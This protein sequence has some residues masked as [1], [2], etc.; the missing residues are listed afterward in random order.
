MTYLITGGA[1]FIGTNLAIAL[2]NDN[3][4]VIIYDNLSRK[5]TELNIKYLTD[6][7]KNKLTFVEGDIRNKTNLE[8]YMKRVDVVF[9]LAGHVSITGSIINPVEDFEVNAFGSLYLLES[10]RKV[11]NPPLIIYSSTNK[12]Y[13]HLSGIPI[14]ESATRYIFKNNHDKKGVKESNP[15]DFYT[16]YGCSK[17]CG[18]QYFIDYHRI[19]G[20]PTIVFRQ[21]CIYGPHQ[22]G[23]EDQGW[24]AW[25]LIATEL[26]LPLRIYGNGKQVRDILHVNDLINAYRIAV[27]NKNISAGNVYNIGGGSKY[28]ISIWQEFKEIITKLTNKNINPDFLKWRPGDQKI[29]YSDNSKLAKQLGWTP[30]IDPLKGTEDIYTWIKS[31]KTYFKNMFRH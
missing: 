28:T 12:V 6:R 14:T 20:I 27:K 15:L 24:V 29:F 22:F 2:L 19:F 4:E 25:F 30:T 31:N 16:P 5:G 17:G 8:Q 9:H 21:S 7:Y 13:G 18:D 10:A 26:G 3:E 23:V 1:G 11:K